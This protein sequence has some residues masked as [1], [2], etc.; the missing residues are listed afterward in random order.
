M[1]HLGLHSIQCISGW[2]LNQ[3]I[4]KIYVKMESS[5]SRGEN[6]KYPNHHL[7]IFIYNMDEKKLAIF[8]TTTDQWPMS[9]DRNH[10]ILVVLIG[11]HL[12]S[13]FRWGGFHQI[14]VSKRFNLTA[15]DTTN[16]SYDSNV[17]YIYV[18]PKWYYRWIRN[19]AQ[20]LTLRIS[21]GFY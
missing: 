13:Q 7:D 16:D 11:K 20:Q 8:A 2:W 4:C 15:K 5:P 21:P 17:I 1:E 19:P 12:L 14:E 18:L 3:P 10:L 6:K 9:P